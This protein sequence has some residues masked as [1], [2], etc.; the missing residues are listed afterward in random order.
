MKV[1]VAGSAP[2]P[3]TS[4]VLLPPDTVMDVGMCS[5]VTVNV[6]AA[7]TLSPNT[8]VLAVAVIVQG[9]SVASAA[10]VIMLSFIETPVCSVA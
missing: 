7:A 8:A 2:S 1:V 6:A 5:R 9:P 3:G 4:M 10:T